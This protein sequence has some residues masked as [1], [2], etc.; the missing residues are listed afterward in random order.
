MRW[1]AQHTN[2]PGRAAMLGANG[3]RRRRDDTITPGFAMTLAAPT[4]PTAP[5]APAEVVGARRR[6]AKDSVLI[7]ALWLLAGFVASA[8]QLP[9]QLAHLLNQA[10]AGIDDIVFF[11][12][13]SSLALLVYGDRRR[14]ELTR[15]IAVRRVAEMRV[16]RYDSLTGL[17]NRRFL[18][19]KLDE[20]LRQ[21]GL[22][23]Q[24]AALLMLHLGGLKAITDV[25]GQQVGD[26]TLIEVVA[27]TMA[28]LRRGMVMAR[29]DGDEFA[30]VVPDAERDD[31]AQIAYRVLGALAEPIQAGGLAIALDG[32]IGLSQETEIEAE[33]L[34]R[35][36]D[37]AL[38]Q[39]R[40]A[41]SGSPV[42]SF[43]PAMDQNIKRRA[44][45]ERELR[46]AVGTPA[47]TLDYQQL[48]RLDTREICG[49]EALARWISPTLGPVPAG[50]FITV[51]EE[52][53]LIGDLSDQLLRLACAEAARWPAEMTL[54]FNLSAKQLRDPGLKDR[55]LAVL[56][57]AGVDPRRLELDIKESALLSHGEV[58]QSVIAQLRDAGMRVALDDFGMGYAT[59]SQL[60]TI[61]IDKIK[62]DRVFIERLGKDPH[63][64]VI[65]RVTIG[66]AQGLG[67]T[68]I[69]EGIETAEQLAALRAAGCVQGQ[70]YLFG[71]AASARETRAL[72][73]PVN[74]AGRR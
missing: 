61:E 74:A 27:R 14:E 7:W 73:G 22:Y 49:F 36:A 47:M 48:V 2:A 57:E 62:I 19:E 69:A 38:R 29:I 26:D 4:A 72:L 70:G 9:Q 18:G 39:A 21:A 20:I 30:V 42:R 11:A 64:D 54:T 16:R 5:A 59:L 13:T 44:R 23:D 43:E 10:G 40:A 63:S 41:D 45:I 15:Q 60:L 46:D 6:I 52:C 56:D 24:P 31:P 66:L 71:L 8:V 55:L 53:G 28:V 1:C 37:W 67:L 65:V 58:A 17:P 33:Q 68:T 34:I 50:E 32:R 35:R 25:H 51:A 12:V 3:L